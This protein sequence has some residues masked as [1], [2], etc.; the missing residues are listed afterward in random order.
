MSDEFKC[1]KCECEM[2]F[3][4]L[5]VL[6]S[7]SSECTLLTPLITLCKPCREKRIDELHYLNP[8]DIDE[9]KLL[10]DAKKERP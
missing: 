9:L 7:A 1:D 5:G 6:G 4:E 10:Y 3:E 2:S 8:Q